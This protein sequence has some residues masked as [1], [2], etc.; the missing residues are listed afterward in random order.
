MSLFD[1]VLDFENYIPYGLNYYGAKKSIAPQL[2]QKMHEIHFK[3]HGQK[4][5][6]FID[7]FG[8]G[9][10]MSFAALQFGYKTTYNDLRSDLCL[11]F[12]SLKERD[13]PFE[14]CERDEFLK[15]LEIPQEKRNLNEICKNL[16]FSYNFNGLHY[17]FPNTDLYQFSN[18]YILAKKEFNFLIENG[19]TNQNRLKFSKK[20]KK[21]GSNFANYFNILQARKN[22]NLENMLIKNCSFLKLNIRDFKPCEVMIYADIPYQDAKSKKTYNG[23]YHNNFNFDEFL[24]W[25][26]NLKSQGYEVF[27]SEYGDYNDN[28][29][30]ILSIKKMVMSGGVNQVKFKKKFEKLFILKDFE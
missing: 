7:C 4:A 22:L 6:H 20:K 23:V 3:K 2:F 10:S 30:E 18:N 19:V 26:K 29:K 9:A 27:I 8:G 11:F 12:N 13:L 17:K 1:V 21:N 16:F 25:C 5:T 24:K 14:F 15:I 28:F